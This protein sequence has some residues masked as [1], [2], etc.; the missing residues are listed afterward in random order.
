M[1]TIKFEDGNYD[2]R[3]LRFIADSKGS[4]VAKG[5]EVD[6]WIVRNFNIKEHKHV[7]D[8]DFGD[9]SLNN[10]QSVYSEVVVTI[11]IQR[12]WLREFINNFGPIYIAFVILALSYMFKDAY[13]EKLSL[14]LT[15]IFLLIGNKAIIDDRMPASNV[16]TLVDNIQLFT[17]VIATIFIVILAI[18]I[19]LD[20]K[21]NKKLEY[22]INNISMYTL[23]PLYLI[24]NIYMIQAAI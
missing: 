5:L 15:S 17:F 1:T 13:S 12:N 21:G 19:A 20:A 6:G 9:P 22:R 8:T 3:D 18:S 16:V 23:I 11:E 24:A 10:A 4:K 7:M 2:Y 14:F